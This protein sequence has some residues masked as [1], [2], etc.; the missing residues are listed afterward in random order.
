ML[1][2][3]NTSF[4]PDFSKDIHYISWTP[5]ANNVGA[6]CFSASGYSSLSCAYAIVSQEMGFS[7]RETV[8]LFRMID[9]ANETGTLYP[10]ANITI[11]PNA[12][13]Y[14]DE[15][16]YKHFND[17]LK[18][19]NQFVKASNII[20]DMSSY[21]YYNTKAGM[22]DNGEYFYMIK[23]AYDSSRIFVGDSSTNWFVIC[24][25]KSLINPV[26]YFNFQELIA[27]E[28]EYAHLRKD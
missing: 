24:D 23:H 1:K 17:A 16:I 21:G 25:E 9:S 2:I 5:N 15:E 12:R 19:Q 13:P 4:L 7:E 22:V 14:S 6:F 18:A 20:F 11:M 28:D 3:I 8:D 26:H 10:K 27:K